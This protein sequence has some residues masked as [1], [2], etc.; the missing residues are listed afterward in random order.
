M[1]YHAPDDFRAEAV[2]FE[3]DGVALVSTVDA[4]AASR[5]VLTQPINVTGAPGTSRGS[6][7]LVVVVSQPGVMSELNRLLLALPP[8]VHRG[9]GRIGTGRLHCPANTSDDAP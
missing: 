7:S 1:L 4:L 5:A 3:Q 2:G 6:V 8:P 9:V